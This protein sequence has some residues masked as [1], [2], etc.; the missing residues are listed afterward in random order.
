MLFRDGKRYPGTIA[1]LQ[2]GRPEV[3]GRRRW[4]SKVGGGQGSSRASLKWS[5]GGPALASIF[6]CAIKVSRGR[7]NFVQQVPG[8]C[9]FALAARSPVRCQ[10][11]LV[12]EMQA[13]QEL[14]AG[15][16]SGLQVLLVWAAVSGASVE[17]RGRDRPLRSMRSSLY[18]G[19]PLQRLHQTSFDNDKRSATSASRN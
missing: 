13:C 17:E 7:G 9:T 8:P 18:G 1:R 2:V 12:K 15:V 6:C 5:A 19:H 16:V 14:V 3:V 11:L 4:W 10:D